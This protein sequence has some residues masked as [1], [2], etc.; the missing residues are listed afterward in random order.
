M[1]THAE[2]KLYLLLLDIDHFK[3]VNDTYGHLVGDDVLRELAKKLREWLRNVDPVFRFG[4]GAC[5]LFC[6]RREITKPAEPT[7]FM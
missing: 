5:V 6:V 7:T 1:A 4:D 2:Q 3:Q